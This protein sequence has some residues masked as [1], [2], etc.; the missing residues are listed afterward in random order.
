MIK[1]KF[2]TLLVALCATTAL[3]ASNTIAY[4]AT[5]KLGGHNGSL[6]IG[7]T[8]FGSAITS[9]DFSNGI[10]TITCDGEVTTIGN[11]AFN[12][13]SDLTSITIPYSVTTIGIY[14]FAYCSGLTSVTIPNSVTTIGWWA[15]YHCSGLTSITIGNSVTTIGNFAFESCSGL[16]SITIPNSVTTIGDRAFC[17]CLGLTSIDVDAANMHYVSM[18]GVLFNN[19]KDTLILHPASNPRTEY[20]IP[21]SVTTIGGW[22]FQYSFGLTSVTIPNS[23]TEIG[24]SAFFNCNGL[25][26]VI[27]PNFVTSIGNY[28]FSSCFGLTTVTIPNS[29]TTIG[30]WAF[31]DCYNLTSITIPNFVTTIETYAFSD[32]YNLTSITIPNSV[33]TIENSAFMGCFGLTSVTIPNSVTTIGNYAFDGCSGLTFVSIPNSVTTIGDNAFWGCSGL[34]SVTCEAMTPP[35][36]GNWCFEYVDKSIP[37]YV[38]ADSIENYH[39]AYQWKDFTDIRPITAKDVEV[40]EIEAEPTESAVEIAWPSVVNAET[41]T[42]EIRLG[43]QLICSVVFNAEGQLVS[44]NFN[45]A[46]GRG[47]HTYAT[48]AESTANGWAYT[49][50]GLNSGTEYTYSVI[51]KNADDRVI[52]TKSGTFTTQGMPMD[53]ESVHNAQCTMHDGKFLQNGQ[54]IIRQGNKTYNVVGQEL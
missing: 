6:D 13:C 23:V 30:G 47:G 48:T 40:T 5:E 38:P 29:V 9:H 49:I 35:S 25:T 42:I 21:N 22:A 54:V 33:T 1:H 20:T 51:A 44:I 15:F 17:S 36:C 39:A 4:T 16:I 34:T 11:W 26:S 52:D 12:N 14:A 28:A 2:L 37:L 31:N 19:T 8:T 3:W 10:G 41:Y 53:V 43:D 24:E 32:C 45:L 27:I 50:A 18:E 46:P 7:K